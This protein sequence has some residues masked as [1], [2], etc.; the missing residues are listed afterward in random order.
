MLRVST[1]AVAVVLCTLLGRPPAAAADGGA[2][3]SPVN[4]NVNVADV[5][6]QIGDG[7]AY[8]LGRHDQHEERLVRESLPQIQIDLSRLAAAKKS[9]IAVLR[10]TLDRS[11]AADRKNNVVHI[12]A[13]NR[14]RLM[15][16][17]AVIRDSLRS[18]NGDLRHLDPSAGAKDTKLT[19]DLFSRF[20]SQGELTN[21]LGQLMN[22]KFYEAGENY[23]AVSDRDKIA[24][25]VTHFDTV[26][27]IER[28][29]A[30]ISAMR[31]AHS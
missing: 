10:E 27:A 19:E 21:D 7:I 31:R 25:F 30:R 15:D 14:Q 17:Y 4:L 24:A 8:V 22:V 5:M 23:D 1:L 2:G 13:A 11:S 20:M 12:S 18:L 6:R 9:V 28:L 3:I 26:R 29:N 16:S